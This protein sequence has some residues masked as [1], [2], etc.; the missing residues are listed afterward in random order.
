MLKCH[1]AVLRCDHTQVIK[2]LFH[3]VGHKYEGFIRSVIKMLNKGF[4]ILPGG[5]G[6]VGRWVDKWFPRTR[7]FFMMSPLQGTWRWND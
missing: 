3:R 5:G 6:G 7:M 4:S 2:M 1:D